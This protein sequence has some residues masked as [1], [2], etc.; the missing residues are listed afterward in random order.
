MIGFYIGAL[1]IRIGLKAHYTIF[2]IR[3]GLRFR[4]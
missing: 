4:V 1:I 2:I 3:K